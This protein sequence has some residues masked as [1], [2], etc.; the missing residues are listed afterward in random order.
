MAQQFEEWTRIF[1]ILF[2]LFFIV[3]FIL[4]LFLVAHPEMIESGDSKLQFFNEV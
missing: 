4:L 3:G 2:D 1:L